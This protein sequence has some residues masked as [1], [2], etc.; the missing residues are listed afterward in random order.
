MATHMPDWQF[1]CTEACGNVSADGAVVEEKSNAP[2]GYLSESSIGRLVVEGGR[3]S[4]TVIGLANWIRGSQRVGASLC[5][6]SIT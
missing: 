5:W 4:L 6:E 1:A 3:L 2:A